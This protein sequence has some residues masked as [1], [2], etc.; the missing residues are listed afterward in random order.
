LRLDKLAS[1][2]VWKKRDAEEGF[3]AFIQFDAGVIDSE[4]MGKKLV[5]MLNLV[6]GDVASSLEVLYKLFRKFAQ[7]SA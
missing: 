7:T 1:V 5:E 4:K 3:N 6:E 2:E